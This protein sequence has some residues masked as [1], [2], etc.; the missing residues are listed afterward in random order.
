MALIGFW[1]ID[2]CT[3][4]C[5]WMQQLKSHASRGFLWAPKF[6]KHRHLKPMNSTMW[7]GGY[8]ETQSVTA[9]QKTNDDT[10]T[11]TYMEA[12][13]GPWHHRL[14]TLFRFSGQIRDHSASHMNLLYLGAFPSKLSYLMGSHRTNSSVEICCVVKYMIRVT[15]KN[16]WKKYFQLIEFPSFS[17]LVVVPN[18]LL[19][20]VC[21]R[22]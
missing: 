12:P 21:F 20:L 18:W 3:L 5:T 16:K 11:G 1:L 19:K 6:K 17:G 15:T 10:L 9:P 7:S 13:R 22:Y 8:F 14:A 4:Y 2:I